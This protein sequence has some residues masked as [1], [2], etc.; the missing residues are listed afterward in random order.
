M[1]GSFFI[2]L[3]HRTFANCRRLHPSR[4]SFQTGRRGSG[5]DL[6]SLSLILFRNPSRD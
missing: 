5:I 4:R 6:A 1:K 2:A 3:P